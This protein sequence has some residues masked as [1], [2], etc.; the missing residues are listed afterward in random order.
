MRYQHRPAPYNP[1]YADPEGNWFDHPPKM[2]AELEAAWKSTPKGKV[3]VGM[4]MVDTATMTQVHGA[5][6]ASLHEVR[7]VT[8]SAVSDT[9]TTAPGLNW[10]PYIEGVPLTSQARGYISAGAGAGDKIGLDPLDADYNDSAH[11]CKA[12]ARSVDLL[13]M[14]NDCIVFYDRQEEQATNAVRAVLSIPIE[15][16]QYSADS[17]EQLTIQTCPVEQK[18]KDTALYRF[19]AS[20]GMSILIYCYYLLIHLLIHPSAK[21]LILFLYS[22]ELHTPPPTRRL[23]VATA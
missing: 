5:G 2:T 20:P 21:P 3:R 15:D 11:D 8:G 16:V 22:R 1:K 12:T 6:G 18:S 7:R 4:W 13:V 14:F 10:E 17:P 23:D 9:A 19:G